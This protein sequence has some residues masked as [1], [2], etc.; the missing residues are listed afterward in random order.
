M[1][2]NSGS[3]QDKKQTPDAPNQ[4]NH[5]QPGSYS[6]RN[7]RRIPAPPANGMAMFSPVCGIIGVFSL[8][9]CMFPAAIFLGVAAILLSILSRKGEPFSHPAAAGLILGILAVFFG[10]AEY[11]YLMLL[12]YM[13]QD[14][15][16]ADLLYQMLQ[17]SK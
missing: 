14:P 13:L 2:N 10:F 6:R 8:F 11:V 16:M 1:E 4:Q 12:N 17:Q 5:Y 15:S 9:Y 7:R 3:D